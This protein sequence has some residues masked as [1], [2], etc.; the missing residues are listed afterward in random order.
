LTRNIARIK[1]EVIKY[2][3]E[4]LENKIKEGLFERVITV[5]EE[6]S[7]RLEKL[8]KNVQNYK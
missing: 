3:I 1:P 7:Y 8:V 5:L 2:V 4:F 6:S